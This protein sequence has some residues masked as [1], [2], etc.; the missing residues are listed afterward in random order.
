MNELVKLNF[1]GTPVNIID[2][3]GGIWFVAKD[4]CDVLE[5]TN[6][7]K[8]ISVLD[9]DEKA[10]VTNSYGQPGHGAQQ[11]SIISESGMYKLV[12]RSRK[13]IAKSFTK[14]VTSEVLP[15]I[16]KTGNYGAT[17]DTSVVTDMIK[18][19]SENHMSLMD[20]YAK[21]AE[22]IE[23]LECTHKMIPVTPDMR[24][25]FY[26]EINKFPSRQTCAYC[27][28]VSEQFLTC[29]LNGEIQTLSPETWEKFQWFIK[30]RIQKNK[31]HDLVCARNGER[32]FN[33]PEPKDLSFATFQLTP[34]LKERLDAYAKSTTIPQSELIRLILQANVPK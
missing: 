1:N 25:A 29:I 22:R 16:R 28:G 24:R 3:N 6:S 13:P 23:T 7:R 31:T 32:L 27:W 8:A 30:N 18:T 11:Y 20:C 9:D 4:I 19:M 17:T 33:E 2:R 15:S 21:L 26:D 34:E 10:T 14:W 12:F 5:L